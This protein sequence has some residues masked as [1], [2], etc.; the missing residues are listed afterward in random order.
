MS[1]LEEPL[2]ITIGQITTAQGVHGEVRVLPL[3]DFPHRFSQLEEVTV[4]LKG[5]V[6]KHRVLSVRQQRRF[7]VL[8]LEGINDPEQARQL[9]NALLK[10]PQDQLMPLPPGHY[11][12]FQLIGLPVFTVEGDY[13]GRV[14]DIF[15]T[16]SNDVYQVRKDDGREVLLPAI[17]QVVKKIDLNSRQIIVCPLAG[18]LDE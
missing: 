2:W 3:T 11:Y 10:I 14:E 12:I 18:L 5:K 15:R 17:K 8:K 9:R 6:R 16:G 7:V 4:V 13:L 1:E